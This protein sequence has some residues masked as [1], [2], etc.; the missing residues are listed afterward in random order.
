MAEVV[1]VIS[2]MRR[3]EGVSGSMSVG[4][5]AAWTSWRIFLRDLPPSGPCIHLPVSLSWHIL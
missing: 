3:E 5:V 2:G 1:V 4:A